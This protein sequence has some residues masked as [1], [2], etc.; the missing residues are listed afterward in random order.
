[1]KIENQIMAYCLYC[2]K[3]TLHKVSNYNKGSQRGNTVGTRRH[4]RAI[5]GYVGSAESRLIIKKLSKRQKVMLKCTVC[6]KTVER[7]MGRRS[8][9]KIEVK[10]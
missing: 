1:M 5:R 3:H 8:K 2:N 6:G 9:K 7:V 4:K 10:R